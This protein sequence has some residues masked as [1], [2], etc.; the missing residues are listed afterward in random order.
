MI[1]IIKT[2][3]RWIFGKIRLS[4]LNFPITRIIVG[5][6]F[7]C[8][9][10]CTV[11]A[12]NKILI[13]KNFYAG[14]NCHF[15]ANAKI[16]DDVLFASY[17]SLVGGDHNIDDKNIIIRKSGREKF[18]RITIK[19]NVW[20]GHGVILL[21]GITINSG[22]IIAAGSVVTKDVPENCIYGGN[23]AKL[24]KVRD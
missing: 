5:S 23:P 20:V 6:N 15:A 14:H 9:K 22:S 11:S 16:G 12:K 18:K 2:L 8:G 10:N 7:F 21:H 4:V 1:N 3:R 17:V 24:I 13:G 19:D